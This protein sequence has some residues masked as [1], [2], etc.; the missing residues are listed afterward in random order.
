[1]SSHFI[2]ICQDCGEKSPFLPG[3]PAC[4]KCGSFSREAIYDYA[5]LAYTLPIVL[6][7]R[8]FDIWRYRELLPIRD[9]NPDLSLGEGGTPLIHAKNLGMMLGLANLY[10]KD[11]RQGPTASFKDRQAA[12]MIA[13]LKEAGINEMVCA[14]TGNVAISYSAYAARAG[15]KLWAFLTSLVPAAKMREVAL[16]GTQVVKI[17]GTYDEAKKMAAEFAKQRNLFLDLGARSI[18]C[19]ESMKT[20]AFEIAEQLTALLG[21][22]DT[23][24]KGEKGAPWRNPDWYIQSVSGGMGPLGVLKGFSELCAMAL[25]NSEPKLG[26][27]QA[28]GCAP[29]VHAWKQ[30]KDTAL[31]VNSPHTL[32]ATLATGDPGRSYTQL[33]KKMNEAKG[34][35]FESVTDEEAFRATHFLAKME[36]LSIEPAAA[37]AFA[38]LV[39]LVR[40]G[41]IKPNEVVVVNCTGHTMSIER[42]ILGEGWERN[43]NLTSDN[44][45]EDGREEGL[46]AALSTVSVDRFPRIAIVDDEP[47]VRTLIRRILQSQG[48]YQ[49]FEASNGKDAVQM[50]VRENP[51]LILLDLMMPDMDGFQVMDVLQTKKETQDIPIIVITAKELTS[52]ENKRL[53]GHIHSLMQKGDFMNDDLLDEVR[54]LLK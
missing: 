49:L 24:T 11:E 21:P 18:P 22:D 15:I 31:P 6:Q 38:G 12:L 19:L 33:Y 45:S 20:I 35:V 13:A 32:I 5:N 54:A 36:G 9:P 29:M 44:L 30:G 41:K 34:G 17:T 25:I 51:N 3:S 47:N 23:S 43:I 50:I 2:A 7:G 53:K 39:K 1:M 10:I 16:Y 14:S 26:I 48:N 46:L 40:A 42:N 28:E 27:I 8:P 37:V 52:S 4:P